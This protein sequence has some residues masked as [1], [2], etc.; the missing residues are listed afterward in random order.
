[1]FNCLCYSEQ[2]LTFTHKRKLNKN[3]YLA[4]FYV[5]TDF[6]LAN[7]CRKSLEIQRKSS[8]LN[9]YGSFVLACLLAACIRAFQVAFFNFHVVLKSAEKL[10]NNMFIAVMKV[11]RTPGGGGGYF[12]VKGYW[13]CAWGRIFTTGL[14]IMGYIFSRVTRTELHIFG[15]S[16]IRKFW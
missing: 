12:L 16:G 15:I 2:E 10:H 9:L 3:Y 7:L 5:F 13:G 8:S 4:A 1:M 6:W 14:T 11:G